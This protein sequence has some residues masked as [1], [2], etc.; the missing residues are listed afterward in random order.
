MDLRTIIEAGIWRERVSANFYRI[1]SR[2]LT[3]EIKLLV[4][5]MALEE[6]GHEKFLRNLYLRKFGEE[7]REIPQV[8]EV[9]VEGIEVK[10]IEELLELAI[11]K[12]KESKAYYMDLFCR[13]DEMSEKESILDLINFEDGHYKRLLEAKQKGG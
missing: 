5:Y 12:E 6:E 10:S 3:G 2:K 7:P 1:L 8:G 4:E 13:V 9:D 11:E